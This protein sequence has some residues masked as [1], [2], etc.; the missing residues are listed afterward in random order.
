M[1]RLGIR[2]CSSLVNPTIVTTHNWG[3]G[4]VT[5]FPCH[6]PT[7]SEL[8]QVL[9]TLIGMVVC[10]WWAGMRVFV[11][12]CA[13]TPLTLLY[14]LAK[15]GVDAK[16]KDVELIHIHTEGPGICVQ[17]QYDGAVSLSLLIMWICIGLTPRLSQHNVIHMYVAP[18]VY[19]HMYVCRSVAVFFVSCL[20]WMRFGVFVEVDEC[21]YFC[22]GKFRTQLVILE[23]LFKCWIT[24]YNVD[25]ML[26]STLAITYYTCL[27]S[28]WVFLILA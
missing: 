1:R 19:A 2:Q 12:G 17:P 23:I 14:A 25:T 20:I 10:V 11:H 9:V 15:H 5:H 8:L 6:C 27:F 7:F 13:A 16:L 26:I 4:L 28:C 22:F 3:G 18:H 24:I 21:F